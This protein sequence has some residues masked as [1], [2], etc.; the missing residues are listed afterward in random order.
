MSFPERASWSPDSRVSIRV[1]FYDPGAFAL[2]RCGD[3]QRL[4]RDPVWIPK[5]LLTGSLLMWGTLLREFALAKAFALRPPSENP[6]ESD[7]GAAVDDRPTAGIIG[8]EG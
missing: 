3:Q 8:A 6:P 5:R 4:L 1:G 7:V 2:D